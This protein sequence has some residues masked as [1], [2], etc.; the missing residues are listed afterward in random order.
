MDSNTYGNGINAYINSLT[1]DNYRMGR[2]K[3]RRGT[4][5][6]TRQKTPIVDP[7]PRPAE[8][9]AGLEEMRVYDYDE[10]IILSSKFR[11]VP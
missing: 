9:Y 4:L 6:T 1:P 5:I 10:R 7:F 11:R 8:P 3:W 2:N